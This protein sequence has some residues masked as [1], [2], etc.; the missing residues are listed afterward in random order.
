M[1]PQTERRPSRRTVESSCTIRTAGRLGESALAILRQARDAPNGMVV[2]AAG[3]RRATD[4]VRVLAGLAPELTASLFPGWDCLPYDRAPPSRLVMGRRLAVLKALVQSEAAARIVVTTPSGLLQRVPPRSELARAELVLRPGDALSR[5]RIE[6]RLERM[7][8][9]LDERVDEPGEAALR[10]QVLDVFPAGGET[11]VRVEH[12]E[13][14]IVALR[15]FDA[16]SQLAGGECPELRILP[17]SEHFALGDGET[18]PRDAGSEHRLPDHFDRLDSL[19]AL[20]PEASVLLDAGAEARI[21]LAW[22]QIR[23][24]YESRTRLRPERAEGERP[25]PPDR[26][27]LTESEWTAHLDAVA[28]TRIEEHPDDPDLAPPPLFATGTRPFRRLAEY[29]TE[30][31]GQG[32]RVVLTGA[33]PSDLRPL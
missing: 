17:A 9:V 25:L 30:A 8:Y 20:L 27:Y 29:V 23:D 10:G 28:V 16:A 3:E 26:L 5:E 18:A 7:G 6:D 21:A 13:G 24:A 32:F 33:G 2:V 15:P 19:T 31:V 1:A 4:L 11:P 12:D 22:E 14:R